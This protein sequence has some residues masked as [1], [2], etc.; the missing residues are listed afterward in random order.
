MVTG[1]ILLKSNHK[2]LKWIEI[3]KDFFL[4]FYFSLLTLTTS[5]DQTSYDLNKQKIDMMSEYVLSGRLHSVP[6]Y[7]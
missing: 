5:Y 7:L 4:L 6:L 3:N 2:L 1:D